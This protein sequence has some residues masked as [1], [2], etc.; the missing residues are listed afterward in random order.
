MPK[1]R[2]FTS[3]EIEQ[4]RQMAAVRL[5]VHQMAAN[6]GMSHDTFERMLKKDSAARASIDKGRDTASRAFR[7]RLFQVAM[8]Q[9]EKRDKFGLIV[10]PGIAPDVQAM[11]FWA[12]TQEGFKRAEK[13]EI[14][15]PDGKPVEIVSLTPE[16]KLEVAK[17]LQEKLKL[18]DDE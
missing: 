2:K 11:K 3:D 12:E 4:I 18:T 7:G 10:K 13:L 1:A 15:G 6:L 17:K 16:Q 9:E 8:G 5:P 14:S